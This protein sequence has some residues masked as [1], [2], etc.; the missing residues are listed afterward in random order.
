MKKKVKTALIIS[1]V[2][3]A[4]ILVGVMIYFLYPSGQ[5]VTANTNTF[6]E[7][8]SSEKLD[9]CSS[10][11]QCYDALTNEGITQLMLTQKGIKIEC[12]SGI[13]YAKKI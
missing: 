2:I 8:P 13:C 7:I 6:S 3:L 1:G 12:S 9:F 4:I 10:Q 11:A 5:S